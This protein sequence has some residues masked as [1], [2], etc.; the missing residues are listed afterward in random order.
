MALA[1]STPKSA[2]AEVAMSKENGA[3]PW[4]GT[5]TARGFVPKTD[6]A[7]ALEYPEDAPTEKAVI[8]HVYGRAN[9]E[10]TTMLAGETAFYRAVAGAAASAKARARGLKSGAAD[11]DGGCGFVACARV[12]LEAARADPRL[13]Y[14][15]RPA[16]ARGEAPRDVAARGGSAALR[17]LA[18]DIDEL[19][20]ERAGAAA[21][22]DEGE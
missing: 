14:L 2:T 13:A 22:A 6:D 10:L 11:E 1:V 19:L 20:A 15:D 9:L 4:R 21:A 5:E 18:S 7:P 8:V 3:W 17:A 12:L 16:G